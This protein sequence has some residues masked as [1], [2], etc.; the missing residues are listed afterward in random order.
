MAEE[1]TYQDLKIELDEVLSDLQHEDT[2]IDKAIEL[3]KRAQKIILEIEKY[4]DK[5]AKSAGLD[6]STLKSE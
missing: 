5:S 4:L 3:H 1:K 6:I 2:D